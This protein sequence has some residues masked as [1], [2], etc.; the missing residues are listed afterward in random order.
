MKAKLILTIA[1]G[2]ALAL[3]PDVAMAQGGV[4]V[5]NQNAQQIALLRWYAANQANTQFTVGTYATSMAFDGANMW[6]GNG[7]S[8]TV[9]KI[10]ASDGTVLGT[11]GVGSGPNALAFDGANIWVA[12]GSSNTVTKLSASTGATLGSV[13][14]GSYP[15]GDGIRWSQHLGGQHLRQQRDQDTGQYALRRRDLQGGKHARS[16]GV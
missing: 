8:N 1:L 4:V 10:R 11:F 15:Y 7:G 6:V 3:V 5:S 13:A 9:T 16:A 14:V 2:V 12:D